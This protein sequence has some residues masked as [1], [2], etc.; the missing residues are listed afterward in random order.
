MRWVACTAVFSTLWVP[1]LALAQA[2]S[3]PLPH[4]PVPPGCPAARSPERALLASGGTYTCKAGGQCVDGAGNAVGNTIKVRVT[5]NAEGTQ[6]TAALP[7]SRLAVTRA[8]NT[9]NA[10]V[11]WQL[12]TNDNR[13]RFDELEGVQLTDRLGQP[14]KTWKG[15]R[16]A[17]NRWQAQLKEGSLAGESCH[18]PWVKFAADEYSPVLTCCPADPVIAN[19]PN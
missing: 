11:R 7:Y 13:F 4:T 2:L 3:C 14:R 5:L 19:E 18:Q 16:T 1:A 10:V 12:D 9:S 15:Q 17:L 8:T 6:C